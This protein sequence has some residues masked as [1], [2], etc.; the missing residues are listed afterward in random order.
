M[1]LIGQRACGPPAHL[2]FWKLE[3]SFPIG[4]ASQCTPAPASN[5]S[6]SALAVCPDNLMPGNSKAEDD[7]NKKQKFLFK[8][9][10]AFRLKEVAN[11]SWTFLLHKSKNRDTHRL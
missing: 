3:R 9:R 6:A 10:V 11:S 1:E 8:I 7:A 5:R 2:L 4:R